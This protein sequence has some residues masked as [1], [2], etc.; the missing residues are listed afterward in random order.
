MGFIIVIVLLVVVVFWAINRVD[1][2]GSGK[3]WDPWT[4]D[5]SF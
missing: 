3:E 2:K 5:P 4:D 1:K